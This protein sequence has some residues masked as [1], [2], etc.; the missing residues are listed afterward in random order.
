MSSQFESARNTEIRTVKK[1]LRAHAIDQNNTRRTPE[2]VIALLEEKGHKDAPG[3][4]TRILTDELTG[5]DRGIIRK[6]DASAIPAVTPVKA[7]EEPIRRLRD[8]SGLKTD[9]HFD[10]Y[11]RDM[12]SS[13]IARRTPASPAPEA[14]E[15]IPAG[16][17]MVNLSSL[18]IVGERG[19][20]ISEETWNNIK[21]LRS[22]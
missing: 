8:T 22:R 20:I 14:R 17:V 10:K 19:A 12:S 18:V 9:P 4:L 1:A 15:S 16:H 5:K 7:P 11:R 13:R 2:R 3:F 21:L 6:I